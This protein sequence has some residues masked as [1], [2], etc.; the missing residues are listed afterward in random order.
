M[1]AAG[2]GASF[3]G[4]ALAAG[5]APAPSPASVE[6]DVAVRYNA[7]F[8]TEAG[9]AII[10]NGEQFQAPISMRGLIKES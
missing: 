3:G 2:A 8:R 6:V 7:V 5:V 9:A 1:S 4:L 10:P